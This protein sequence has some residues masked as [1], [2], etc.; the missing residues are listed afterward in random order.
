[1]KPPVCLLCL[2]CGV[3]LPGCGVIVGTLVDTV[4]DV[5][6]Y[7]VREYVFW[8]SYKY[9]NTW[10]EPY[11]VVE[12]PRDPGEILLGI[13]VSGGGSRSAYFFACVMEELAKIPVTPKSSKTYADE[14]DYIS[15]VSGGSLASAYYCLT[16][17]NRPHKSDAKF[18][19]AFKQT[20][21]KNFEFAAMIKML[22]GYWML[23]LFTYYDRGDLMASVWDHDFFKKATFADLI[24]AERNGAPA[25]IM[26]TTNLTDGLKFV[27]TT[28]REDRFNSSAYFQQLR[29]AGFIKHAATQRYIPF[30]TIGFGSLNSDIRPYRVSNAVV[31]SASV[32]NL[33]GPVTL[34]DYTS[35]ERLI[36]LVDGGVYD[37]YGV[38]SLMQVMTEYLDRNPGK[39]AK[40]LIIDGSGYFEEDKRQSNRFTVAYYSERP[41]AI[42]WLRT[43]SYME[44]VFQ[45][46]RNFQNKDGVKPY[47]NLEFELI[48]LY[49]PLPSQQQP[50]FITKEVALQ[51]ILRP[52]ITTAEFLE[53][54]TTIQTRFKLAKADAE[55]IE[56][57]AK[58]TAER[59]KS[60]T[61]R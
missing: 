35:E 12:E 19:T 13:A 28:I 8:G 49:E 14:V 40:I 4:I 52:D 6:T 1:M 26:N 17:Y 53:R 55:M 57:V 41:L 60:V 56:T 59:L 47:R 31:A 36:N 24:Q 33:L 18:F 42:S 45:S 16:K 23:N 37:N 50:K 15:S 27:F 22:C 58:Q 54:V 7:P 39:P 5:T 25:L 51:K 30:R 10:P 46:A 11:Q 2:L 61:A 48:S 21:A 9:D 34:R 32:P 43:K 29:D 20:M 38:E 3:L 44:Y